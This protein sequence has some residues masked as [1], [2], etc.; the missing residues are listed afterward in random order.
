VK[1]VD[2]VARISGSSLEGNRVYASGEIERR[3]YVV[4]PRVPPGYPTPLLGRLVGEI[5]VMRWGAV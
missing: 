3:K 1:A 2:E 5:V 4:S